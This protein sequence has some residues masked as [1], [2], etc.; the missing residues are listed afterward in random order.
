MVGKTRATYA[1]FIL[2]FQEIIFKISF[3]QFIFRYPI[4][5]TSWLVNEMN[6][7]F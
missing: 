6:G 5:Y 4:V 7:H 1:V 3:I 2:V